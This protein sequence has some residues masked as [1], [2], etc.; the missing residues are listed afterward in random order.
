MMNETIV[1]GLKPYLIGDKIR[2]LRLRK[3]MGLVELGKHTGLSA[4]MLSKLERGKLFPTLPTLL[5]IALVFSVGLDYFFTD[6]RKR[7]VVALARKSDRMRFPERP[8]Q[9]NVAYFFESLDYPATQ[10]KIST[11]LADFQA[12]HDDK[13]K[14]HMHPGHELLYLF[15]GELILTIGSTEYQLQEG[16]SIYFDS[17][18]LHSY[19]KVGKGSTSAII[20]TAA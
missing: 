14:P 15:K 3:S 10:R 20:V 11:F 8:G 18:V 2:S 1:N 17:A 12:V 7:R 5:R 13:V 9:E 16:D 19:C 6:E 4:A